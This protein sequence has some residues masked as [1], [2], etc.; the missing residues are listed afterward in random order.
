MKKIIIL[1][2]VAFSI[3]SLH[4]RTDVNEQL[5]KLRTNHV[6]SSENYKNYKE[7]Y[8]ISLNNINEIKEALL[9]I[10]KLKRDLKYND[11]NISNNKRVLSKMIEKFDS[12]KANE[13]KEIAKETQQIEKIKAMISKL[14]A[15]I[16]KRQANI[17][18]YDTKVA[19]INT[20]IAEWDTKNR[21]IA[22]VKEQLLAKEKVAKDD[23]K[24]WTDKKNDYKSEAI[25][26]N[27]KATILH[28]TYVRIKR[29]NE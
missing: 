2:T 11:R 12:Y 26:W 13:N 6:N 4:A 9:V 20:E 22:Q 29:L 24:A 21:D 10:S 27:K 5:G 1:L 16:T 15:N 18:A 8:D 23:L 7:N 14:E 3:S 25:K 19:E 17:T 28:K